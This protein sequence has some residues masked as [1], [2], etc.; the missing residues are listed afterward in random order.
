MAQNDTKNNV[1][2]INK[3]SARSVAMGAAF[4]MA[5][6]AVGPG[7]LTQTAAFTSQLGPNF[8]FAILVTILIDIVVQINIWRIITV[9]GKHAQQIANDIFPGLG[10]FL[11]FL[12][13]V[14]GFFF[15][16]GNVAGAGLGLNVLFGISAE[17][18]GDYS[19]AF[20]NYRVRCS[21]CASRNGS[22]SPSLSSC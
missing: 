15:N 19:S 8:G 22:D 17:N 4:V 10:Y 3:R 13:V 1:S 14:G 7:F 18:G 5:M 12:I 6:S 21:Q 2:S 11:T 16:I 20:G 9:S